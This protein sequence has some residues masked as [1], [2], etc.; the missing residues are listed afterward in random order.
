MTVVISF[1]RGIN[2]GGRNMIKMET[3]RELYQLMGLLDVQTYLQSGNIVYRTRERNLTKL[4]LRLEDE[5][6]SRFGF[7]PSVIQ[8]TPAELRDVV[9][10]NPF[11]GREGIEPSKLLVSFLRDQAQE[12]DKV[13]EIPA[14]PDELH[15]DGREL[16]IYFANGMG[17]PQLSLAK[18][19]RTLKTA[20]TGRNWNTVTKLLGIAIELEKLR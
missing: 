9:A 6:E 12:I 4:G 11:A 13:R 15:I 16:F 18:V 3:L 5:I 19:E 20:A 10:R 14:H 2:V 7:R 1:L 8:R 17:R